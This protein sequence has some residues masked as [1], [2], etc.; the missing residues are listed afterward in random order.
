M[1]VLES[2]FAYNDKPYRSLSALAKHI[3]G[4]IVNGFAWW[5]LGLPTKEKKSS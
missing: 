5:G 2:G 4:Q 3:T 1:R